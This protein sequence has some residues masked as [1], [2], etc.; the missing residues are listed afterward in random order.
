VSD[1][2]LE[3]VAFDFQVHLRVRKQTALHFRFV[4]LKFIQGAIKNVEV[5]DHPVLVGLRGGSSGYGDEA[6]I[7]RP[8]SRGKE[9][10]SQFKVRWKNPQR[11]ISLSSF[12][13][14]QSAPR[15]IAGL[16]LMPFT[17]RN[18]TSSAWWNALNVPRLKR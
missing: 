4:G 12:W 6:P 15:G 10:P 1:K 14:N 17:P 3:T 5:I 8:L 13:Q 7:K 11:K 18:A 2:V 9:P 16:L